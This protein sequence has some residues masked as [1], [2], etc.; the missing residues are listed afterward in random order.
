MKKFP[1][2]GSQFMLS[3]PLLLLAVLAVSCSAASEI[4]PRT[5]LFSISYG[6][7]EQQLDV[8][9]FDRFKGKQKNRLFMKGG[10]FFL[11]N[12]NAGKILE[13][14]SFGDLLSL[15]YNPEINARPV[16][17]NA[18]ADQTGNRKFVIPY[19]FE[20][21]GEIVVMKDDTLLVEDLAPE[22][23]RIYDVQSGAQVDK[24]ILRF[25]PDHSLLEYI[26][27]EG[28]NGTPFPT[29]VS[30]GLTRSENLWVVCRITNGFLVYLYDNSGKRLKLIDIADDVVPV[31]EIGAWYPSVKT[32][33][34]DPEFPQV[35][36][37]IDYYPRH[38]MKDKIE[39]RVY[40]INLI[41]GQWERFMSLP[42]CRMTLEAASSLEPESVQ[43]LYSF[44]G[45]A[46][47]GHFFFLAR[48]AS[49]SYSL[50]LL[51]RSGRVVQQKQLVVEDSKIEE[52]DYHLSWEGIL[53]AFMVFEDRADVAWWR[54]DALTGNSA[55]L[56]Q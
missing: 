54:T 10:L 56:L 4:M 3:V 18:Y 20:A 6:R 21:P 30:M 47:R 33:I 12:G 13:F 19:S 48:N 43:S 28:L 40:Q 5:D 32:V 50:V 2:A 44:I 52:I 27:Q 9:Q 8:F 7:M 51:D 38:N 49:N 23:A 45:I 15:Y 24:I 25:A 11:V 34:P 35:H 37:Q 39:S 26:G 14:S 55:R 36:V 46:S 29:I 31:P 41:S 22:S 53:S 17:L 1:A 16:V 42:E